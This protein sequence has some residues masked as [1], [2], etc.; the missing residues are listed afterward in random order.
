LRVPDS[1]LLLYS[2][3]ETAERNLRQHA[4]DRGLRAERLVFAPRLPAPEYLAR[5]R[6]ADLFLD[7]LPYN[8][9]TTAS[10]ALWAGLPVLT[11]LGT[12][13]AGRL[14]ASL[15][16][17]MNLSDLIAPTEEHYEAMAVDLATNPGRL[18]S[19]NARLQENRRTSLLFDTRRFTKSLE[20]AYEMIHERH[21][22]G[23]PPEHIDV[24]L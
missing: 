20:R 21:H 11:C 9:G 8:A 16:A 23:L 10:D 12:T 19:I 1:V 2:S 14:A 5:F 6:T 15:L 17:A 4:R 22:A 7:T 13:F 3:G 18:A 24:S